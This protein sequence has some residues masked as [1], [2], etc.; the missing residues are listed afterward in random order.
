MDETQNVAPIPAD[1][2]KKVAKAIVQHHGKDLRGD[3]GPAGAPG[4][5]GPI[6]PKGDKG[7]QG[8]VGARGPKG[9]TGVAGDRGEKGATGPQGTK[10]DQ[11]PIGPRGERGEMGPRG[12]EGQPGPIGDRGPVGGVGPRGERGEKGEPGVDGVAGSNIG[13]RA[14]CTKPF[15]VNGSPAERVQ[16]H[17]DVHDGKDNGGHH[18]V[19]TDNEIFKIVFP[20]PTLLS[21]T[22]V[23]AD[24]IKIIMKNE[25][26][27]RCIAVGRDSCTTIYPLR[28]YDEL[29]VEVRCDKD[30]G[31]N[32]IGSASPSFSIQNVGKAG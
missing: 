19:I 24:E 14:R 32:P 30:T 27:T 23:G 28:K 12:V 10:G 21:A 17:F 6:G 13:V 7:D 29:T 26:E 5:D 22:C 9:D 25:T 16:I 20:G 3:R 8:D 11:G 1:H 4:A 2:A 15:T 31:I 18:S